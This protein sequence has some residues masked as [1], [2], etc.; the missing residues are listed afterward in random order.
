MFG[1]LFPL[2][3]TRYR[4]CILIENGPSTAQ[5]R[6]AVGRGEHAIFTNHRRLAAEAETV[7]ET[8]YWA[9]VAG[10]FS[11]HHKFASF[12]R[13]M[14]RLYDAQRHLMRACSRLG[15]NL[16]ACIEPAPGG[17]TEPGASLRSRLIRKLADL[18]GNKAGW[19][20]ESGYQTGL[21]F[22]SLVGQVENDDDHEAFMN[23]EIVAEKVADLT[24]A[25]RSAGLSHTV[26]KALLRVQRKLKK[27]KNKKSAREC[28]DI[29]APVIESLLQ[30]KN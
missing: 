27:S 18:F 30:G 22:A 25:V 24:D 15:V 4:L 14:E 7:T 10:F 21:I 6:F 23:L 19:L 1:R 3:L 29:L 9:F 8:R 28:R 26:V 12:A 11:F 5:P 2:R 13:D 17:R 20:V 16:D